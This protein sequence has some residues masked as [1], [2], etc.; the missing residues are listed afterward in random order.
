MSKSRLF[1]GIIVFICSIV[2]IFV[3]Y[4]SDNYFNRIIGIMG[5]IFCYLLLMMQE[6]EDINKKLDMLE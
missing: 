4:Q 1:F 3:G 2:Q 6:L 5:I